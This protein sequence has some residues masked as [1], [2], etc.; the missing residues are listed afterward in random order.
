MIFLLF[1][2]TV[3]F[4]RHGA[5]EVSES[6]R[7]TGPS[8]HYVSESGY[9]LGDGKTPSEYIRG[10]EKPKAPVSIFDK[11]ACLTLSNIFSYF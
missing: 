8:K 2:L 11:S 6:E 5:Q 3:L 4:N 9:R 7:G 10:A 1:S